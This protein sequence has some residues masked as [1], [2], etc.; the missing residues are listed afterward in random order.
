LPAAINPSA[1]RSFLM[2]SSGV[3]LFCFMRVPTA[4]R[5]AFSHIFWLSFRGALQVID[6]V[7][8]GPEDAGHLING[9]PIPA[10]YVVGKDDYVGVPND[11]SLIVPG[12][13]ISPHEAPDEVA[14]AILRTLE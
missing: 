13:H 3:C 2:T 1:S 11:G 14:G 4:L 9:L 6:A 8:L 5:A 7:I 12:G 10:L